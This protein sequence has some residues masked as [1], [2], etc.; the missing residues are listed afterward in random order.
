MLKTPA[1]VPARTARQIHA[2]LCAQT[3]HILN[4]LSPNTLYGDTTLALLQPSTRALGLVFVS[5]LRGA[6]L[7]SIEND[8]PSA[9]VG[10]PL[11]RTSRML[12][13]AGVRLL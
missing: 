2:S 7:E 1:P 5:Q 8:D 4:R 6:L 12:R 13:A 3:E 11:I 9:L 10:L